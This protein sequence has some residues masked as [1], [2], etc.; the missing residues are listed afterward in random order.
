MFKLPDPLRDVSVECL[1]YARHC[2]KQDPDILSAIKINTQL[3]QS[4]TRCFSYFNSDPSHRQTT[5][6]VPAKIY[7]LGIILKEITDII[8][9]YP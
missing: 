4:V 9:F 5:S 6:L 2:L 7:I 8:S 3:P 1:L